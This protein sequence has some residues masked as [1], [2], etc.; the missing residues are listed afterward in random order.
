MS[1]NDFEVTEEDVQVERLLLGLEDED[2]TDWERN[3]AESILRKGMEN[4]G[5]YYL[6]LKQR[7]QLDRMEEKYE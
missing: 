3:F 1:P 6:T 5:K 7:E 2:L 4:N